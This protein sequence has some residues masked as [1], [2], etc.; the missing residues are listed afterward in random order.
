[1]A[2]IAVVA[3]LTAGL[4]PA[5][6]A[7]RTDLISATK[8]AGSIFGRRVSQ[9]R[10][11]SLLVIVQVTVCV[12][13]LSCAGLL[14]R[15]MLELRK[16]DVGFDAQQVYESFTVPRGGLP[17]DPTAKTAVL[18]QMLETVQATPG[19]AGAARV[20]ANGNFIGKGG[21]VPV[22]T[23]AVDGA[24]APPPT[25]VRG[26]MVS[27][28]FFTTLGI[29]LVRGRA[30]TALEVDG[31]ADV[32]VISE[33][34]ARHFWP[35]QDAIG[36]TLVIPESAFVWPPTN[37]SIIGTRE[38]RV[39][40]VA[41]DLRTV[42]RRRETPAMYLPLRP[43]ALSAAMVLIRPRADSPAALEEIA[44][45]AGE[46][47]VDVHFIDRMAARASEMLA[48]FI[49]LSW[50]S[51][52]L[53]VLALAMAAVGLYGVMTFAVNQRVREI[54]IRVALGATAENVIRLFVRQGMMLVVIGAIVG[55]G[56][57]ALLSLALRKIM[58]GLNGAFDLIAF[59]AV[60]TLLGV[61]ALFAC[62]LPA[63]RA[64]R[65]DPMVALR[66]E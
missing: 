65:V 10:L 45:A 1:M 62:W 26:Q 52:V 31:G 16:L 24:A 40:G 18:R 48:P 27:P 51:G 56:G 33:A 32:V 66:A 43:A 4:L 39:V 57:G 8:E 49:L 23:P 34:A 50:V 60:T 22:A 20:A 53:G 38:C 11:R 25:N 44:R 5:L 29:P 54:G 15:N 37:R 63:R 46:A 6:Q 3:T 9:S 36:R 47:G 59:G 17:A 64:T 28:E 41:R 19:V 58:F 13:L 14:S 21:T 42:M 30:F 55:L 2:G 12:L 35:G 61:V 7:S